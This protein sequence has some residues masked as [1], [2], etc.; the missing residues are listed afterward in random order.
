MASTL[1]HLHV[2]RAISKHDPESTAVVHCDSGRNFSYGS[3]L[4][5]VASAKDRLAQT[6]QESSLKGERVAFLAENGYDY[7]GVQLLYQRKHHSSNLQI[8]TFL[9]ILAHEAVALPLCHTFPASELRY[10]LENSQAKVLLSTTKF[11]A[12]AEETLKEGLDQKPVL[13]IVAKIHEGSTARKKVALNGEPAGTGGL[14]LY[15][16]GTTSRPV[17]S[18]VA[19]MC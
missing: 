10:I 6:V 12:K 18:P 11:Q 4:Y 16:S 17:C 1:P 2:F 8:V 15:T 3:L 13:G 14:M 5:D 19:L 9:S 7:V